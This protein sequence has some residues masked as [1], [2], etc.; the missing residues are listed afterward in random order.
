MK[1]DVPINRTPGFGGTPKLPKSPVDAVTFLLMDTPQNTPVSTP[2]SDFFSDEVQDLSGSSPEKSTDA[3]SEHRRR[4]K[5]FSKFRAESMSDE[6][7]IESGIELGLSPSSSGYGKTVNLQEL[8]SNFRAASV[9]D[10]T[11]IESGIELGLSASSSGYGKTENLNDLIISDEL[12]AIPKEILTTEDVQRTAPVDIQHPKGV[13]RRRRRKKPSSSFSERF[14]DYYTLKDDLLGEG[15][16][17]KVQTCIDNCT[18][19]EF[20]VKILEKQF[21]SRVK[22]FKEIEIFHNCQGHENIIQLIRYFEENDYF[23]IVFEKGHGGPL[24]DHIQKRKSFSE[25]EASMV[26]KDIANALKFL[27]H[28]GIAHRDLKPENI[29]CFSQDQ[30]CPVKICDF[31]LGSRV[32][33]G[34]NSPCSTP[35]LQSP[36][37]SAEFMAP[38]IVIGFQG[39]DTHYD[40]RCDLWSLGVVMYIVLCG[41]PPFYGRCGSDCGWNRGEV[42]DACQEMLFDCITNGVYEYPDREWAGISEEA[43]DLINHLL[44]KEATQ[45]YSAEMVLIHPWIFGGGPPTPLKTP[46]VIRRNNSVKELAAFTNSANAM[47]RRY[48][49]S[50]YSSG[51]RPR[52]VTEESLSRGS[53]TTSSPD[54]SLRPVDEST[55]YRRRLANLSSKS[56]ES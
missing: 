45:R 21:N 52:T 35:E 51:T 54:L 12:A 23:Y 17:A 39:E 3:Q 55:I 20:A 24:L 30:V 56:L 13:Q 32:L 18:G 53:A 19:K 34:K 38:E 6:P 48:L 11:G 46:S 22:V 14:F 26:I 16:S 27:H 9:S 31:D 25:A 42:C 15:S 33:V 1:T 37:G 41:Y 7:G 36:V 40:K 10:E 43:K 29:L 4:P 49:H 28:K 50:V 8:I 2:G 5:T 44:V 47:K